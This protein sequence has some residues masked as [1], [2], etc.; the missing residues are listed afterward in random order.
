MKCIISP[1]N[2]CYKNIAGEEYFLSTFD[3]DIFYLYINS[4]SII[5]GKNQNAYS[6]INQKY[7]TDN[8]IFVVRR[9]SG[10]GAVYHDSGNLNFS[11]IVKN[12]NR[13]IQLIFH[14]YAKP[15]LA[16]LHELGVDACFSGRNDL[17]VGDKKISGNAQYRSSDK[18]LQHGTLLFNSDLTAIANALNVSPAKYQDRS[19]KS[20][21]SRVANICEFLSEE[22]SM[23]VFVETI[24]KT[25]INEVPD[26]NLY[27]LTESDVTAITALADRKYS[28]WEWVYGVT[29]KFTYQ[30][31]FRFD[32]GTIELCLNVESGIIKGFTI[33]GDFFGAEDIKEL[34]NVFIDLP[35]N[36]A[37]IEKSA[38]GINIGHYIWGLEQNVL[39]DNLFK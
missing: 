23:D 2:S 21:K 25:V 8:D 29:P 7:V 20:V 16:A 30:N 15:I 13:D 12:D 24:L 39:I 28:T 4:P 26:A 35:Y 27:R 31:V 37:R 33:Y 19:T 10:G 22:I 5:I 6:E 32:K 11:F 3:D 34:T 9:L 1:F 18:I 14:D 38:S 17:V 36:R